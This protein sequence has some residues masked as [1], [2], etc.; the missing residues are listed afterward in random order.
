MFAGDRAHHVGLFRFLIVRIDPRI[1]QFWVGKGDN[2]ATV[3]GIGQN[4][5]ISGHARIEYHFTNGG[6]RCT[7]GIAAIHRTIG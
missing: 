4:L 5:L 2:L 6:A 3:A 1:P 7:K